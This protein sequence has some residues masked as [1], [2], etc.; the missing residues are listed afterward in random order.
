[1]KDEANW[2]KVFDALHTRMTRMENIMHKMQAEYAISI[3]EIERFSSELSNTV[4]KIVEY[5][6]LDNARNIMKNQT[7]EVVKR[8]VEI[9]HNTYELSQEKV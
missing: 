9:V 5:A 1:M 4:G 6:I 7:D 3:G 2:E 8:V